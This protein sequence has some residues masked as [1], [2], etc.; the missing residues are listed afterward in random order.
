MWNL[1]KK[2]DK[3]DNL[4]QNIT[5]NLFIYLYSLNDQKTNPRFPERT[6]WASKSK[7]KSK[8]NKP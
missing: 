6:E 3:I 7:S 1:K 4:N 2:N 5:Q 8:S